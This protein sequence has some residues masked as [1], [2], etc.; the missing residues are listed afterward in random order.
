MGH[1]EIM[2]LCL[3]N[4]IVCRA[5][6]TPFP[7]SDPYEC[8]LYTTVH[9][10]HL[11]IIQTKWTVS[12]TPE[13]RQQKLI[14]ASRCIDILLRGVPIPQVGAGLCLPP[15]LCTMAGARRR[16]TIFCLSGSPKGL[17]CAH[18]FKIRPWRRK[19]FPPSIRRPLWTF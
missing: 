18:G 14:T 10:S 13:Q 5:L 8:L 12:F 11:V 2:T 16:H 15:F 1:S 19:A 9:Q 3:L 6:P 4:E 7:P 17:V